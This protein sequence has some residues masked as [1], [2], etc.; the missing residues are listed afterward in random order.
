MIL[1]VLGVKDKEAL[2]NLFVDINVIS[3]TPSPVYDD[4]LL[5]IDREEL[6]VVDKDKYILEWLAVDERPETGDGAV[7]SEKEEW[8]ERLEDPQTTHLQ[9]QNRNIKLASSIVS[10]INLFKVCSHQQ[11]S[12]AFLSLDLCQIVRYV[13]I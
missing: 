6:N 10:K 2:R 13:H 11:L 1:F 9:D 8:S 5:R 12:R 3:R 7:S 4:D